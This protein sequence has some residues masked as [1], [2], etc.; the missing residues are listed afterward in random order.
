MSDN[1]R[2]N[3][4]HK[5]HPHVLFPDYDESIYLDGNIDMRTDILFNLIQ[6][7]DAIRIPIHN[8]SC[9]YA[10]AANIIK[11]GKDKKEYVE[12]IIDYLKNENFPRNYGLNENCIIYRKHNDEKIIAMMNMWWKL[13]EK[14]SKRDQLSLSFVLWKFNVS[15]YNI[16]FPNVRHNDANFI[17]HGKHK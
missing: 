16:A 8:G 15:P 6:D 12:K 14:F 7:S 13:I 9:I 11:S 17:F 4:W 10:E 2:I 3:R 1:V 5:T